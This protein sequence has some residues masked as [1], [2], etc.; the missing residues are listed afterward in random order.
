MAKD[1][2]QKQREVKP[3]ALAKGYAART[4]LLLQRHQLS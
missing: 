1:L 3:H 4:L 2:A